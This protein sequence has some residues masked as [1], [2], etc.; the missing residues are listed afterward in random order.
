MKTAALTCLA[1][2]A[3]GAAASPACAQTEMRVGVMAH[4]VRLIDPKNANKEAGPNVEAEVVF[5]APDALHWAGSPHP[6]LLASAN[7]QGN[8]SYAAAGLEWQW[9]FAEGWALQPG[10][11]IA[12]HD[13]KT[14]N[15]FPNGSPQSLAFQNAHVL[16]GSRTLF[17]PTLSLSRDISD[18]VAVE[19]AYEH[20]SNGQILHHG[21]NQ[22]LDEA[23]IRLSYK[24]GK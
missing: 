9:R 14:D 21:R 3:L 24:F 12:V 5:G 13:G 18:H 10:F 4:N 15:P 7:T 2:A 6:Y 17:H 1:A 19:F 16:L 8:T 22:G 11:G 23:G 20:L